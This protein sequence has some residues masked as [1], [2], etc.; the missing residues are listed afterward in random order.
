MSWDLAFDPIT[1][2]LI[3]DDAGGWVRT[4]SADTAILNQLECHYDRWWADPTLGSTLFDRDRFTSAP[5][6]LVQAEVQ[7]ALD[8]LVAEE[9]IANL[10]VV[11]AENASKGG[12]VD[13]RT[14][15]RVVATGLNVESLLPIFGGL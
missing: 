13:V 5:A 8:V 12:R 15:Y 11:A 6:P 9:L 3:R 7:R 1:G 2:D 14:T 10:E 4:E